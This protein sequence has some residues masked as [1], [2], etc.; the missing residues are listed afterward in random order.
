MP[1]TVNVL[2]LRPGDRILIRP[3]REAT[4][5]KRCTVGE[6]DSV[7]VHTDVSDDLTGLPCTVTLL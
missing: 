7:T 6:W 4:V 5:T 2:D 3:G 1:R